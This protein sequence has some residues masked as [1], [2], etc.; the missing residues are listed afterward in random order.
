MIYVIAIAA[1]WIL[2]IIAAVDVIM[3][4]RTPQGIT[5]WSLALVIFPPVVLPLYLVFG[6][7]RF[8]GYVRARRRG[9]R[10]L[11]QSMS[12]LM[13]AVEHAVC[14]PEPDHLVALSR[15]CG[16]PFT[17]GNSVRL[18]VNGDQ[19]YEEM[20][21]QIDA[22]EKYV[23]LFFYIYREDATGKELQARLIAAR[24]RGVAVYF[25]Y[26]EIGSMS[27]SMAYLQALEA[28][29][30]RCSG[31][32]T[33]SRRRR[34][35]LR[36][37]FRNHRKIVVVDGKLGLVG[38]INVGD[39]YRGRDQEVG[40]WRDSHVRLEGPAVQCLQMVFLEDWYWAQRNIPDEL[41]WIE[42]PPRDSGPHVL[43]Y[44]SGPADKLET[45]TLLFGHLIGGAKKRLWI[46]TPYFVPDEFV[47]NTL[48]LAAMRG[49]NVRILVPHKSDS[50]L[51]DVAVRSYFRELMDAGIHVWLYRAGFLHQKVLLADD[52]AAIGTANLDNRSMRINFEVTAVVADAEF[53]ASV[54]KM[55]DHDFGHAS[56]VTAASIA[57]VS[58]PKRFVRRLA[59]TLSPVL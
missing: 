6:E 24:E 46:A 22:A 1:I 2:G 9:L 26:D 17:G 55:L 53:A 44:P 7:R 21:R 40:P 20:F 33:T 45:G 29:G 57:K 42:Q 28:A 59:R 12:K 35:L 15:L 23:L 41:E 31:F 4:G 49:V 50:V 3:S 5:A 32:R 56:P 54:A 52:V 47:L 39:E 43:M 38:G 36:L 37:N 16:L 18:L 13:A 14:V 34:R 27:L 19:M 58:F 10:P 51:A 48:Q 30:C 25:M 8:R 11:D